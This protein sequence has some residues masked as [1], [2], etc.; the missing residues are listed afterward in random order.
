[1]ALTTE[2]IT[3]LIV[4]LKY[5]S[6]LRPCQMPM[7]IETTRLRTPNAMPELSCVLRLFLSDVAVD[8]V[9]DVGATAFELRVSREGAH[10]SYSTT[11]F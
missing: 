11:T 4:L 10:V 1:M 2:P 3:F 8:G 9:L 7:V 6:R 5:E